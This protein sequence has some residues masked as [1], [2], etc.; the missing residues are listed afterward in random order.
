MNIHWILVATCAV[1]T[2]GS[3]QP[4]SELAENGAAMQGLKNLGRKFH[5]KLNKPRE[6]GPVVSSVTAQLAKWLVR[7]DDTENVEKA[8]V[9]LKM[10]KGATSRRSPPRSRHHKQRLQRYLSTKHFANHNDPTVHDFLSLKI[11]RCC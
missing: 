3:S 5:G 11:Q 4:N 2:N 6:A 7:S 9:L 10:M 1:A 8:K